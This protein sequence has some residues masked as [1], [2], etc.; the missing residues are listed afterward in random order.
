MDAADSVLHCQ[1]A[2]AAAKH[3]SEQRQRGRIVVRFYRDDDEIDRTDGG[4][5]LLRATVHGEVAERR[6]ADLET[7]FSDR[8]EMCSPRDQ[9]DLVPGAGEFRAVIPADGA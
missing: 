2:R 6:A 9:N 8:R 4:G 5:V 1:H 3:G 7:A